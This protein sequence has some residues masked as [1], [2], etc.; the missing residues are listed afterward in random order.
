MY[1]VIRRYQNPKL[2]ETLQQ[3][4][5]DVEN[6]IRPIPGFVAYY[7]IKSSDGGATVTVCQD[8][9]GTDASV[10]RAADWVRQNAPHAA[11]TPPEI[12]EGE[13]I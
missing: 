8:K 10:Q 1:G 12:T 5:Q 9:S 11:G 4:Q 6:V 2:I 3:R 7:I 13:V